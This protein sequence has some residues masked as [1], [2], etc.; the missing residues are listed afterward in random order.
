MTSSWI[1]PV[2]VTMPT[3]NQKPE[4]L[5][6]AVR[7]WLDAGALEIVIVDDGSDVPIVNNWH[8]E[9]VRIARIQH[10]GVARA[11]NTAIELISDRCEWVA[12]SASDDVQ[13]PDRLQTQL[14]FMISRDLNACFCDA[15]DSRTGERYET[16]V[17]RHPPG[18]Q[19]WRTWRRRLA[20]DNRF[21]GAASVIKT[22]HIRDYRHD[23]EMLY[24]QDWVLNA[25]I[26]WNVPGGWHYLPETLL[27]IGRYEDGLEQTG[28]RD[29][30]FPE[31]RRL[32]ERRVAEIVEEHGGTV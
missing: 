32:A 3:W 12:R 2:G 14:S 31:I 13:D 11:W 22:G 27:T 18:Y 16:G 6:A 30:R 17:E 19:Y 5:D 29:Q 7:S 25:W 28:Y 24:C 23:P 8:A 15:R 26:E 4:R 10:G 9:R 20:T 21:Y 1:W